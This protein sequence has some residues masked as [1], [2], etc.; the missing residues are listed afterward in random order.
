MIQ[1]C[2]RRFVPLL[3]MSI[4]LLAGSG[5]ALYARNVDSLY[6]PTVSTGGGS[7][8]VYIVMPPKQATPSPELRWAIGTVTNS[9]GIKIDEIF[10]PRSPAELVQRALSLELKRAGYTLHTV[11][12]KPAGPEKAIDLIM[13]EVVVDQVSTFPDLTAI[14]RIDVRLEVIKNGQVL[15]KLHYDAAASKKDVN[16]R[17]RMAGTVLQEAL[18]SIMLRVVPD[19]VSI[20]EK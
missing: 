5:C 11:T 16:G 17:D 7:G 1:T 10:S 2:S 3:V 12:T 18:H 13:V 4:M 8:E 9:D 20:L 14:C 19:I 6:E 15:K